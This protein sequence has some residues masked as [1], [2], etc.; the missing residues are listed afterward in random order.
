DGSGNLVDQLLLAGF[1]EIVLVLRVRAPMADD[2]VSA[3]AEG[4][5]HLGAVIVDF[6]VQQQGRRQLE[7]VEYLEQA[8]DA[9]TIAVFAPGPVVGV[10]MRKPRRVRDAEPLAM[11]EVLEVQ[12]DMDGQAP[13]VWPGE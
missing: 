12:A 2:L 5:D 1:I 6:R 9:D 3:R 11:G 13:A 4:G 10:G 7:L 8:P